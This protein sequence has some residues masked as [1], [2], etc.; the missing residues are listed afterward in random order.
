MADVKNF[1]ESAS[2]LYN[3]G[4][5]QFKIKKYKDAIKTFAKIESLYPF[6]ELAVKGRLI[7]AVANYEIDDYVSASDLVDDYIQMYPN[8]QNIDFAYYLRII[9]KYMQIQDID[10]DPKVAYEVLELSNEFIKLFSNSEYAVSVKK[11]LT[12]VRHHVAGKEFSI[13]NFYLKRGEYIAALK[14]FNVIL[15]QYDDT[16]YFPESIYRIYEIYLA[17]GDRETSQ[18]YLSMFQKC[19][20]DSIWINLNKQ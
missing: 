7:A 17:L 5:Q 16:K 9:S 14:R 3:L 20:K 8:S 13:G 12:N 15:A 4:I 18:K 2:A 1:E 19:C 11:G 6:S 10:L